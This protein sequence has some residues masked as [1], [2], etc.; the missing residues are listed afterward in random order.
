[1]YVTIPT[2]NRV[3]YFWHIVIT[4]VR[5]ITNSQKSRI[6]RKVSNRLNPSQPKPSFARIYVIVFFRYKR[7]KPTLFHTLTTVTE[8]NAPLIVVRTVVVTHRIRI[9]KPRDTREYYSTANHV[10]TSRQKRSVPSK[11]RPILQLC[12]IGL[13]VHY[14]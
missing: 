1:M 5:N 7:F 11:Q 12:K 2:L 3:I 13:T 9:G 6:S 4:A 10:H 8:R 14:F